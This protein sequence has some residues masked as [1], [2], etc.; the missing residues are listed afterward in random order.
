MWRGTEGCTPGRRRPVELAGG[1][2]SPGHREQNENEEE[3]TG[4]ELARLHRTLAGLVNG[5]RL[6]G[7]RQA[8]NGL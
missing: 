7:Q 3:R 2:R 8:V 1:E 4:G 6:C 5:F